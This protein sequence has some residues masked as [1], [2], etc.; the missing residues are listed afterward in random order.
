MSMS[1]VIIG[2]F[3]TGMATAA[4]RHTRLQYP[5]MALGCMSMIGVELWLRSG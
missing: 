3:L 1:V 5:V 4:V 2:S